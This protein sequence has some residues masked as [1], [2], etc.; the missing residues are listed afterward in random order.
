MINSYF[1]KLLC[2]FK[3]AELCSWP[4][5]S[6]ALDRRVQIIINLSFSLTQKQNPVQ[7]PDPVQISDPDQ[8]PD[9]GQSREPGQSAAEVGRRVGGTVSDTVWKA[10][11]T[12]LRLLEVGHCLILI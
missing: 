7:R 3:L 2:P 6:G 9:P 10:N 11:V 8:R 4:L 5:F 12:S 1:S